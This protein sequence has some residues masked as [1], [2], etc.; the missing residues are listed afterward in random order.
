[1][2][3]TENEQAAL[4]AVGDAGGCGAARD[5][6]CKAGCPVAGELGGEG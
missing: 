6:A 5:E 1:M 2:K 4:L 3:Y